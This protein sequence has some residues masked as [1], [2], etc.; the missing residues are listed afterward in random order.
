[1]LH[2]YH[3]FVVQAE[4]RNDLMEFLRN[5]EVQTLIHY[6]IPIHKQK[7]YQDYNDISLQKT[8]EFSANILSL[9][10]HPFMKK[11]EVLRVCDLIKKFYRQQ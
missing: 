3:L 5:N 6:P 7:C 10:I 11:E 1:V 2:T 9:P 8:E 4:K